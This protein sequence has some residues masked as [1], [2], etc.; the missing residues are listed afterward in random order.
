MNDGAAN[1]IIASADSVGTQCTLNISW[2]SVDSSGLRVR[3]VEAEMRGVLLVLLQCLCEGHGGKM[4]YICVDSIVSACIEIFAMDTV[5]THMFVSNVITAFPVTTSGAK[6]QLQH[7]LNHIQT[8]L[9]NG[10]MPVRRVSDRGEESATPKPLIRQPC[11]PCVR[12]KIVW[13]P[14]RPLPCSNFGMNY[15]DTWWLPNHHCWSGQ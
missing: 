7:S 1:R 13:L 15:L 12:M 5:S 11:C 14:F 9:L 6:L 8:R 3:R 4:L 10:K 2:L